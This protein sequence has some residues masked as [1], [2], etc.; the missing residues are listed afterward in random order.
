MMS[1][2]IVSLLKKF[3]PGR[4]S[5][6]V[7]KFLATGRTWSGVERSEAEVR[8]ERLLE[9]LVAMDETVEGTELRVE[10]IELEARDGAST[11]GEGDLRS[12]FT[13]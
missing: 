1:R 6:S 11:L 4:P 13:S 7:H 3:G 8:G 5:S 10:G 12:L 2:T 9:G